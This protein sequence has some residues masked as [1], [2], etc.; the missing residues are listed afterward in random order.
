MNWG[1]LNVHIYNVKPS[2]LCSPMHDDWQLCLHFVQ[3]FVYSFSG[4]AASQFLRT[5][6]VQCNGDAVAVAAHD[7]LPASATECSH[8]CPAFQ[9]K[10]N[11]ILRDTKNCFYSGRI[12]IIS[13]SVLVSAKQ[14]HACIHWGSGRCIWGSAVYLPQSSA[15]QSVRM[16]NDNY[17]IR[18]TRVREGD[19]C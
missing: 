6:W 18:V 12:G 19:I 16:W 17:E 5:Y 3:K 11:H 10:P 13:T 7:K 8:V 15:H 9:L 1:L 4:D 2:W 14:Y